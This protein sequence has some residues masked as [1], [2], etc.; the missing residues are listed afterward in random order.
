MELALR[1]LRDGADVLQPLKV[2]IAGLRLGDPVEKA[3]AVRRRQGA[4]ITET[5]LVFGDV[6][7]HRDWRIGWHASSRRIVSLTLGNT[8][9][10]QIPQ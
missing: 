9:Y 4:E 8:D 6:Q 3:I 5:D 10:L 2:S 7:F 1:E